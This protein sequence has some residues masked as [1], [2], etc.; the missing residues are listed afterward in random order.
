MVQKSLEPRYWPGVA[1]IWWKQ[2]TR[3]DEPCRRTEIKHGSLAAFA[4]FLASRILGSSARVAPRP[5]WAP[6]PLR[7]ND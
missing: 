5:A 1:E 7:V 6:P 4:H 3:P 2:N